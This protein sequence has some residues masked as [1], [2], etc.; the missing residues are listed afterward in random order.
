MNLAAFTQMM[1]ACVCSMK[2][3]GLRYIALI[4]PWVF[5]SRIF[6][7]AAR[8]WRCHCSPSCTHG[9]SSISTSSRSRTLSELRTTWEIT[10]RRENHT[11]T[12]ASYLLKFPLHRLQIHWLSDLI[13]IVKE[14]SLVDWEE[15]GLLRVECDDGVQ[16][17]L[18]HADVLAQV[19]LLLCRW[20]WTHLK[21]VLWD[22][23]EVRVFVQTCH[24]ITSNDLINAQSIATPP[25]QRM[26]SLSHQTNN[27]FDLADFLSG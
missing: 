25:P 26:P 15:E 23:R 12:V 21:E 3:L 20:S 6:P 17:C 16:D 11:K 4:D 14:H 7:A 9:S 1:V 5:S 2:F 19:L 10:V 13:D 18:H 24:W 8:S 22:F 27:H